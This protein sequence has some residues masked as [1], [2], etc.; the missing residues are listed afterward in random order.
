MITIRGLR[1]LRGTQ[2]VLDGI[3]M[4]VAQGE[5]VSVIG[6]SGCGKTTLL[7]CLAGLERPTSG[8]ILLDL[9][10]PGGNP[11]V[12][13]ATLSETELNEVRREV[14]MVFQYAALFD[15]LSVR[16]NIAFPIDR[17]SVV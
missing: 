6:P 1:F 10:G 11:E 3:D 5:I 17:K 14:G 9:D 4:A 7:K 15:S 8:S 16:E 12:D 13:L 2:V